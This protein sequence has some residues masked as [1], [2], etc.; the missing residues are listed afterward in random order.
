MA[1][2]SATNALA[3]R[4]SAVRTNK[5]CVPT[6]KPHP[7]KLVFPREHRDDT[8]ASVPNGVFRR[9]RTRLPRSRA[10]RVPTRR[11][12][13]D[14]RQDLARAQ[15]PPGASNRRP[16]D[17]AR[18]LRRIAPGVRFAVPR[19]RVFA[20]S[21]ARPPP[22][23]PPPPGPA[24]TRTAP[25]RPSSFA[26]RPSS[27]PPP[28]PRSSRRSRRSARPPSPAS[29]RPPSS[30]RCVPRTTTISGRA[31]DL[32]AY[33]SPPRAGSPAPARSRSRAPTSRAR[34]GRIPA[35]DPTLA[36]SR[37]T[38]RRSSEVTR[39]FPPTRRPP[40]RGPL[41]PL[42]RDDDF[43]TRI[44][45]FPLTPPLPLFRPPPSLPPSN[46][47]VRERRDVR[48]VPGPHLPPGEGHGPR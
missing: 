32:A 14:E 19:G 26:V 47:A 8:R 3:A 35:P 27:A 25:T 44:E 15:R 1:C 13:R 37:A 39:A 33:P 2:M 31:F 18:A 17:A 48:R 43:R 34:G 30:P 40:G 24:L 42:P 11:L 12:S 20:R 9:A 6:D 36:R 38:P 10:T 41:E 7:G 29:P 5:R 4:A 28:S 45:A 16:R 22:S 46:P 23:S 21:P